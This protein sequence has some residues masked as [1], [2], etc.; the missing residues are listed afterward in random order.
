MANG[1]A[2]RAEPESFVDLVQPGW[3]E[4]LVDAASARYL[5]RMIVCSALPRAG[6]ART[7]LTLD[8]RTF[9]AGDH[10]DCGELLADASARSAVDASAAVLD[11]ARARKAA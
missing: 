10:V 1:S 7:P 8:G 5:S 9:F 11:G 3:R 2:T 6:A 4:R